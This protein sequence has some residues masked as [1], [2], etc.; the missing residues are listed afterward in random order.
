MGEWSWFVHFI[1][2]IT[3]STC[4]EESGLKDTSNVS[5]QLLTLSRSLLHCDA[6]SFLLQ[7]TEK[8]DVLPPKSFTKDEISSDKSFVYIRKNGGPRI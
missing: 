2:K 7:T 6:Q 1:N 3:S 8:S 4:F 5:A